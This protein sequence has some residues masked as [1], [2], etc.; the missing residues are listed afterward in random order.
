M[1]S[2]LKLLSFEADGRYA[3]DEELQFVNDYAQSFNLRL[4]T[5]QRLR[6]IESVL[7]QQVYD[8]LKSHHALPLYFAGDDVS[9]KWKQDTIRVLRYSAVA[10]LMDDPE[11]LQERFLLW[12]Q[13]IM[14]SFG[15]QQN[16]NITYG[17]VQEVVK[18]HLSPSQASLLCPILEINRRYLS[19]EI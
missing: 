14:R 8:K 5:Y 7:V 19:Q 10:M 17:I 3:T 15:V 6:A 2:Q 9:H 4:Q 1:L 13:T 11:T 18:E 16:C 12:F